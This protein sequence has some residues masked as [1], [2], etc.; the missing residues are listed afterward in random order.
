MERRR[1]RGGVGSRE[2]M[3]EGERKRAEPRKYKGED[4]REDERK[5]E[6]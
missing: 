1:R 3:R 4:K 5:T 2:E 6:E